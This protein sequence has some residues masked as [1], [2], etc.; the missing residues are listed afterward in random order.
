M[1]AFFIGMQFLM[2]TRAFLTFSTC[3]GFMAILFFMVPILWTC[4]SQIYG[5]PVMTFIGLLKRSSNVPALVWVFVMFATYRRWNIHQIKME[6]F[7]YIKL[8]T[9]AAIV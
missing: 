5:K 3:D 7:V 4:I 6:A 8:K 2:G 1:I 9:Y